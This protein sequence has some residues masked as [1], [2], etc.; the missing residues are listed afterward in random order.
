MVETAEPAA[1]VLTHVAPEKRRG[2][3]APV[4]GDVFELVREKSE[5]VTGRILDAGRSRPR[6]ENSAAEDDRARPR[7]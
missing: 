4:L 2:A 6:K 5:R 7:E 3:E 1:Q